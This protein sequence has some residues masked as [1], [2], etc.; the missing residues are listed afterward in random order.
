MHC[1]LIEIPPLNSF[2]FKR[3]KSEKLR[4]MKKQ[5]ADCPICKGTG[6]FE[7]PAKMQLD[8]MELKKHLAIEL[9]KKG[10][11]VRQIQKALGYKSPR[12]IQIFL[13]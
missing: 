4:D 2:L 3:L 9:H 10:Y 7:L 6:T 1:R 8:S 13:K 11:S 5:K 12:S